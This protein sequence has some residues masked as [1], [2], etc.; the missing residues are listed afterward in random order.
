VVCANQSELLN[1][2]KKDY[3]SLQ[4]TARIGLKIV[5]EHGAEKCRAALFAAEAGIR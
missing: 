2:A 5:C 1:D 3:P 4:F